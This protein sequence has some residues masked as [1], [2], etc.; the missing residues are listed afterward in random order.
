MM[1]RLI[2]GSVDIVIMVKEVTPENF[3]SIFVLRMVVPLVYFH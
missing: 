2:F 3:S 1:K